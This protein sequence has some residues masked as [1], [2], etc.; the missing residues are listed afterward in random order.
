[1]AKQISALGMG[2]LRLWETH[3]RNWTLIPA[4]L[5][6]EEG[7]Y[8]G[9][10]VEQLHLTCGGHKNFESEPEP[11]G[12]CGRG[13]VVFNDGVSGYLITNVADIQSFVVAHLRDKHREIENFVYN[14]SPFA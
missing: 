5:V 3:A 11:L 14:G 1:M 7:H 9:P 2:Q 12:G 10:G 13:V 8:L 4:I 6:T